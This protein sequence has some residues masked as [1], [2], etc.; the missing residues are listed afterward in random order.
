M[1][2]FVTDK[3]NM[4]AKEVNAR[5]W[6]VISQN[7]YRFSAQGSC[8][9]FGKVQITLVSVPRV[10]AEKWNSRMS[11][12]AFDVTSKIELEDVMAR[13]K[14]KVLMGAKPRPGFQEALRAFRVLKPKLPAIRLARQISRYA[15][16][17]FEW[18]SSCVE[19]VPLS[20][21]EYQEFSNQHPG[22]AIDPDKWI[23]SDGEVSP[24][25]NDDS[26]PVNYSSS[27]DSEPLEPFLAVWSENKPRK[28]QVPSLVH[29]HLTVCPEQISEEE[30]QFFCDC[31]ADLM[32][33]QPTD[34]GDE[35]DE[36]VP[37][38]SSPSITS[39]DWDDGPVQCAGWEEYRW[40]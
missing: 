40:G 37:V 25:E 1:L 5:L 16:D 10:W 17:H 8:E 36:W 11:E 21:E 28:Y 32:S 26:R 3:K 34:A 4:K 18:D 13:K 7:K 30:L 23:D 14:V 9:E 35:E 2:F 22:Y 12:C 15:P 19:C 38:S 27:L 33:S 6:S 31:L 29:W 39:D 20:E 24:M